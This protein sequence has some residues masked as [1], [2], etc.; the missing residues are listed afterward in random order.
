M[1]DA[2]VVHPNSHIEDKPYRVREFAILNL[3][4]NL[5]KFGAFIQD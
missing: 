5:L 2:G 3:D 4:G 1:K